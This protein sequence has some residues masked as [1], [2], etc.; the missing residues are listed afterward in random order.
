MERQLEQ[1]PDPPPSLREMFSRQMEKRASSVFANKALLDP[2]AV[3]VKIVGRTRQFEA[4]VA[5]LGDLGASYLPPLIQIYGSP[6]TG[7]TS[8]VRQVATEATAQFADLEVAY[9]NLKECRSLFA[10]ANQILF[11][12]TGQ[13]ESP[14][15]GLDGIFEELWGALKQKKYLVLILDEIDSIFEDKRYKPSDFLYRFL[16]HREAGKPP[17]VGLITITNVLMGIE[18]LLDSRVRSSMGNQSVYF[19]PYKGRE[20]LAILEDRAAAFRPAVLGPDVLPR[21][22]QLAAEEH[23][24][25]RRALDLLRKAGELADRQGVGTVEARHLDQA[26]GLLDMDKALRAIPDLPLHE[27]F[28]LMALNVLQYDKSKATVTSG[29]LYRSYLRECGAWDVRARG[30]RRFLDFLQ[31]LE[32]HGLVGSK[33]VSTGRQGRR[34]LVWTEGDLLEVRRVVVDSLCIRIPMGSWAWYVRQVG[35]DRTGR[36]GDWYGEEEAEVQ[37]R[38]QDE[39]RTYGIG[40]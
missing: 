26:A 8:V 24:D 35:E 22:A 30:H 7:K 31:D 36:V 3:S 10:A 4:L 14:V 15:A 38:A 19:P 29:E 23:G 32:M 11:Q 18:S 2:S 34:K 20:V 9:V 12:V 13:K 33:V 25:A 1:E 39:D 21:C 28:V 6:G 27:V 5:L 17:V 16:R 37:E 40:D